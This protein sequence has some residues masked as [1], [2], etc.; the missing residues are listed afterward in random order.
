MVRIRVLVSQ[1][2]FLEK[3]G[4]GPGD[5]QIWAPGPKSGFLGSNLGPGPNLSVEAPGE[6]V[7]LLYKIEMA[8]CAQVSLINSVSRSTNGGTLF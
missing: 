5:P 3:K 4:P 1:N 6:R 8:K 7:C 2:I